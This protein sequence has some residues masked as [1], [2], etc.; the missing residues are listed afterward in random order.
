MAILLVLVGP[1][2][3]SSILLG[4]AGESSLPYTKSKHGLVLRV[5]GGLLTFIPNL[6]AGVF[7]VMT[8]RA[9]LHS[10]VAVLTYLTL[11]SFAAQTSS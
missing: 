4:P 5:A 6:Y 10:G 8:G 9:F 11:T 7:S 3:E 1:G 2:G